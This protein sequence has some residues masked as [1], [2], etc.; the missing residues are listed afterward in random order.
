MLRNKNI[1]MECN[2]CEN[3]YKMRRFWKDKHDKTFRDAV[4]YCRKALNF[5]LSIGRDC[6]FAREVLN[7]NQDL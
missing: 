1:T 7:E 6:S 5:C 2:R 3:I 4:E